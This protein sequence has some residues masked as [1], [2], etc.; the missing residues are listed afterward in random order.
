MDFLIHEFD[1]GEGKHKDDQEHDPAHCA[2]VSHA[3]IAEGGIVNVHAVEVGA[4]FGCS[5][6]EHDVR[7]GKDLE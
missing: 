5:T 6:R 3:V 4:A 2:G 7:L 1:C